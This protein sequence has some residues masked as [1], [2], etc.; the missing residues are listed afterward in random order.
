MNDNKKV[1]WGQL[2]MIIT[3]AGTILGWLFT[4]LE[5][6]DDYMAAIRIDVETT[7]TDVSWMK[8]EWQRLIGQGKI[9][10]KG[11]LLDRMYETR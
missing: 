1:T 3:I 8:N 10:Q 5:K 6:I 11:N 2:I 9:T 7:K 4:K